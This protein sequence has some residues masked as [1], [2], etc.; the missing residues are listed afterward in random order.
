MSKAW[1]PGFHQV[2][3]VGSWQAPSSPDLLYQN[4][5]FIWPFSS[6]LFALVPHPLLLPYSGYV[7]SGHSSPAGKPER[8]AAEL[9]TCLCTEARAEALPAAVPAWVSPGKIITSRVNFTK[10]IRKS[11]MKS[12]QTDVGLYPRH[13]QELVFHQLRYQITV[14]RVRYQISSLHPMQL[15]INPT[16]RHSRHEHTA[17]V[18]PV[19]ICHKETAPDTPWTP[20]LGSQCGTCPS[21]R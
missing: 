13:C 6:V 3:K 20:L 11:V 21:F 14:N 16:N 17:K 15:H 2:Q 5:T 19:T 10:V 1:A 18:W 4:D 9:R 7:R 8:G 12:E